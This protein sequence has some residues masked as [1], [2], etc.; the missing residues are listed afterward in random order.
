MAAV[1]L[2]IEH[3]IDHVLD[4]LGAGDLAVL[5]HV[6]DEQQRAARRL[7]KRISACAA[8]RTWLTVPG[9]ASMRVGP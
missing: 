8:A 9:A 1:A 7:G 4:D 6:A 2:E 5:G 3:R